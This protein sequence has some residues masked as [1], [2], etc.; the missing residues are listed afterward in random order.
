MTWRRVWRDLWQWL[1]RTQQSPDTSQARDAKR[2]EKDVPVLRRGPPRTEVGQQDI[3]AGL[4]KA[5][6][7]RPGEAK[8]ADEKERRTAP[9]ARAQ[10]RQ[11]LDLVIGLDF[12]TSATKVVV[13]SPFLLGQ[14]AVAVSFGELGHATS[15]YLLPTRLWVGPRGHFSLVQNEEGRLITDLKLPLLDHCGPHGEAQGTDMDEERLV[16][17][18]AY[19]ALVLRETRRRHL[20]AE[21]ETYGRFDIRW[22]VNLGIPSAGYDDGTIRELFQRA[23]RA[24]WHLSH[25]WAPLTRASVVGAL[26]LDHLDPGI[27]IDVVPEV[28]AQAAGYARST[29]RD[30]GLHL[31][32]DVGATTLDICGFILHAREGRD[33]YELLTT[34]VERLGVLELHRRRLATLLCRKG[35]E[36]KATE[37]DDPL[38]PVPESLADYHP[39]CSCNPPD[40]D[41]EFL[42]NGCRD[43]MRDLLLLK[44]DRD[45]NSRRW[46]E[47]LPVFLCGG[48]N[49]MG[50]Y[51]L[52]VSDADERFR[53]AT[54]GSGLRLRVLPKPTQLANEDVGDAMFHRLSVAYGLSFDALDIGK[55]S[56]PH[57]ISDLPRPRRRD[58]GE[59]F[60]SKDQV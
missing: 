42:D 56:P 16:P 26:R 46:V 35:N 50:L 14:R 59:G 55:I 21:R 18:V 29:L 34:T 37:P 52:M 24:A 60:V 40:V 43:I 47:G 58:P 8:A 53:R 30:P 9:K 11:A 45:P 51:Q 12:G 33:R 3:E 1:T 7:G 48:G 41:R 28:A 36:A 38:A 19:L 5:D 22:S 32:I 2:P 23:V 57:E 13:R 49:G 4:D 44:R 10:Q 39:G 17:A 20:A 15:P 54:V 25:G 27:P 31:L 6:R